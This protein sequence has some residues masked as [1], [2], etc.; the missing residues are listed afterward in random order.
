MLKFVILFFSLVLSQFVSA[1][2]LKCL[3]DVIYHESRGEPNH[4]KEKVAMVVFKRTYSK[5][6]PDNICSVVYQKNQFS[7]VGKGYRINEP[8]EYAKAKTIA[9]KMYANYSLGNYR[10]SGSPAL[11]FTT[12]KR[13]KNTRVVEKCG[14]H[15]FM[16]STR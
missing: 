7:W 15:I 9:D 4:C 14:N 10:N 5:S 3:T 8:K 1:K 16:A 2:Q 13:F 12:G 6:F 11:Y